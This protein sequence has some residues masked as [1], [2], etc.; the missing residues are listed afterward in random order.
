VVDVGADEHVGD[1]APQAEFDLFAVDQTQSA[2][3]R[4]GGVRD[5]Q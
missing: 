5:D 3:G 4:Q 1:F 2:V